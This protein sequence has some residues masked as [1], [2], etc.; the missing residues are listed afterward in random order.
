MPAVPAQLL[1]R[2]LC[3]SH[4]LAGVWKSLWYWKQQLVSSLF[5]IVSQFS[6]TVCCVQC[7]LCAN[8]A[9][10]VGLSARHAPVHLQLLHVSV[11]QGAP[12]GVLFDLIIYCALFFMQRVV[13]RRGG[14]ATA[15]DGSAEG[16]PSFAK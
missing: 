5:F 8:P 1:C 7:W 2:L 10:H 3:Q 16:N 12:V 11:V 4:T 6:G 15:T 14:H 13:D 9:L